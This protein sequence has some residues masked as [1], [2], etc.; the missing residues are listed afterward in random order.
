MDAGYGSTMSSSRKSS[1]FV[2]GAI[3][4]EFVA[5]SIRGHSRKTHIGAHDIFLGQVRADVIEDKTVQGIEYSAYTPMAEEA[6]HS[7]REDA[8]HTFNLSCLHIHH[9]VGFVPTGGIS[10]FVFVSAPH[11]TDVFKATQWIVEAIKKLVPIWGKE[12]LSDG[13]YNWKSNNPE[14]EA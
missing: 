6:F 13:T 3:T 9:S 2:E 10:L 8:F 7:I 4:P 14:T 11:R 12:V 1:V 5:D